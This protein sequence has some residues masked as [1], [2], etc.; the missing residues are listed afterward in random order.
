MDDAS[1]TR[2]GVIAGTPQYMSPEQARGEPLD[3]RSDLF[4]LGSVLYALCVGRP[5]F[6]A[7]TAFGVL[8]RIG[9]SEPTP[10]RELSPEVP[11][12]LCEIIE[13][14]HAKKPEERFSTAGEVAGLLGR[15]LAHV[16]QPTVIPAPK[17]TGR[18]RKRGS[19]NQQV[20]LVG[21]I[22]LA[23]LGVTA[24]VVFLAPAWN[25]A[26]NEPRAAPVVVA[27]TVQ[28]SAE[29]TASDRNNAAALRQ[30]A[31]DPGRQE[32]QWTESLHAVSPA[33]V[34]EQTMRNECQ[35][36]RQEITEI[37]GR[38]SEPAAP[39]GNAGW[40]TAIE[41]VRRQLDDLSQRIDAN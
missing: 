26:E 28:P 27:G 17:R 32:A 40:Q 13:K 19:R 16:Q 41:D 25:E 3:G 8:R 22:G 30:R 7:E 39:D 35:T 6:R 9:E 23:A 1:L 18:R 34:D 5:P 21:T 37:E 15:W 31:I 4:S 11:E 33:M 2:S 12:W 20:A 36:M 14:L 24:A 29:D 10:I 38:W